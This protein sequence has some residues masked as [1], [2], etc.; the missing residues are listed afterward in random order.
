MMQKPRYFIAILLAGL[1]YSLVA[2]EPEPQATLEAKGGAI[3]IAGDGKLAAL[4]ADYK[5]SLKLFDLTAKTET[6]TLEE[7]ENTYTSLAFSADGKLLAAT[8]I[9]LDPPE[10]NLSVWDVPGKK[11]LWENKQGVHWARFS[12]DGKALAAGRHGALRFFN[13]KL[14]AVLKDVPAHQ[15]ASVL[16]GEYSRDGK[17]LVT[18]ADDQQVIVWNVATGKSQRPLKLA[19]EQA[20]ALAISDDGSLVAVAQGRAVSLYD[21]KSGQAKWMKSPHEEAVRA[22]DFRPRSQQL[23]SGCQDG[24]ARIWDAASGAE[25]T[26]IQPR[27]GMVQAVRYLPSGESLLVGTSAATFIYPASIGSPT[28]EYRL[29]QS[30]SGKFSIEARYAGQQ[31]DKVKLVRKSDQKEIEVPLSQLSESDRKFVADA[32]QSK[33]ASSP[34]AGLTYESDEHEW[35]P[36]EK[37]VSLVPIKQGIS[38]LSTV[39][40]NFAGKG[41]KLEVGPASDGR[42]Q[43]G[44]QTTEWVVGKAITLHDFSAELFSDDVREYRWSQGQ[45]AVKM[46]KRDE[47]ICYLAGVGGTMRG[48]GEQVRVQL[49][50]DGFWYLEGK[51]AQA[52]LSGKAIALR[53]KNPKAVSAEVSEKTWSAGDEPVELLAANKGICLLGSVSGNF[54]GGGE[55]IRLTLDGNSWRLGGQ[56][57]QA[58]L[59]ARALVVQLKSSAK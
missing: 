36:G 33:P 57:G 27:R 56:S 48:Y 54:A 7:G 34:T 42:W 58:E 10:N 25:L 19:G 30:A 16:L 8:K 50:D 53:W 2:Q 31:Q 5:G 24:S 37:P 41:D 14:G 28:A 35:K 52:E 13:P 46:L 21:A 43:L 29:W 20:S 1:T 17:L 44:G 11:R 55:V 23:A 26:L 6:A 40:G 49:A 39:L 59:S 38:I 47:G 22:L 32:A 51:T 45:P 18:A 9:S 15:D 12:P 4:G 3:A